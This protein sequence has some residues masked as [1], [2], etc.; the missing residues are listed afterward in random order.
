M[1]SFLSL[2]S[3]G[4]K[5]FFSFRML[6]INLA[7]VMLGVLFWSMAFY[8][9]SDNILSYCERFLPHSWS[10]LAHSEGFLASLWAFVFKGLV[11][12]LIIWFVI[13]LTL[14]GNVFMSIFYTPLVIS[15]LHKKYYFQVER[16]EFGSVTFSIKYFLKSLI[17]MLVIMAL[18]TPLYFIPIIGVFLSLIPHFLFFKN[19]MSLDVGSAIFK[20][21][22]KYQTLLKQYKMSH[23]RFCA[24]CYLFSLIPFFNFFATLLQT[25]LLAHYFFTLKENKDN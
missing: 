13:L 18:L 1:V 19:T 14:I 11:Y 20:D 17:I 12:M 9:F 21:Y 5:D 8:Y 6:V 23:Y 7:P 22:E 4:W 3:K 16:E 2:L 24:C 25:I 15:Y 10:A